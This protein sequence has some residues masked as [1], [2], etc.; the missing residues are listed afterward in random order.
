MRVVSN[1][2]AEKEKAVLDKEDRKVVW[3]TSRWG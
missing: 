2:H 3:E 1:A